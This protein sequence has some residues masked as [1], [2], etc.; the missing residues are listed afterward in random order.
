M[1]CS[2]RDEDPVTVNIDLERVAIYD[3]N[4]IGTRVY[5]LAY[6]LHEVYNICLP[7]ETR[8]MATTRNFKSLL[9]CSQYKYTC[10]YSPHTDIFVTGKLYIVPV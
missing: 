9:S 6:P 2:T 3:N 7:S 5:V 1:Q 10:R 8:S 4:I